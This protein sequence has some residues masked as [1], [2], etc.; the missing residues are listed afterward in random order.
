MSKFDAQL[1][2]WIAVDWGTSNLRAW[3]MGAKGEILAEA[4]SDQGMGSLQRAEF[5]PA[6]LALIDAH[7]HAGRKTPVLCCGMVGAR[8]GWIEADY[9]PVPCEPPSANHAT[10]APALDP[11]IEVFLLPGVCQGKPSDVMRGEE[12]Q[13]AGLLHQTPDF[14]GVV[15]LPGTHT[16]WAHISAGE[17]VSFRTFLTGEMFALLSKQSVLRHSLNGDGLDSEA[18]E[19]A[20]HDAMT[21]PQNVTSNLFAIR[22]GDLLSGADASVSRAQL[23]GLL[24]GLEL[25]GSRPYWLGQN[26]AIIGSEENSALYQSALGSVGVEADICDATDMTLSGLRAAHKILKESGT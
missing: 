9:Q 10:R 16:K 23:S 3:V 14:D 5:E 7:L 19:N 6:L 4:Q 21:S 11:R 24:I 2:D 18:F 13:I 22:A 1:T 25:A 15:C 8:Q 20:I 17:I 12:T 26:V